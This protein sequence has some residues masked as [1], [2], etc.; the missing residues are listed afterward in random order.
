M[1]IHTYS[2]VLCRDLENS[3]AK[4]HDRGKAG[5]RHGTCESNTV[6]LCCSNGKDT[7]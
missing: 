7:I 5:A 3:L 1:L 4:R 2:A 6:A